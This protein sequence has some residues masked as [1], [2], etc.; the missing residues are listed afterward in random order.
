VK[1][2]LVKVLAFV[3]L[4]LFAVF[5]IFPIAFGPGVEDPVS[6]FPGNPFYLEVKISNEN[7]TPLTN[8]QYTCQAENVELQSGVKPSDVR[9][10]NQGQIRKFQG[11]RATTI[12]CETA[13]II[14]VPVKS[15]E[16]HLTLKYTAYPWR[17]DRA[18]DYRFAAAV[19]AKGQITKWVRK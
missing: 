2:R 5:V 14:D 3:G 6:R 1:S 11:R 15:A 8:V 7:L 12:R 10:L 19:D 4:F 13:Y 17:I 16:F 9:V 18:A